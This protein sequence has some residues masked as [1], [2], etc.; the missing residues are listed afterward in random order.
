MDKIE[1]NIIPFKIRG[2]PQWSCDTFAISVKILSNKFNW[3]KDNESLT[4][5][6]IFTSMELLALAQ[7]WMAGPHPKLISA[8]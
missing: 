3:R 2:V 6:Y 7:C 4:D 8:Q 5:D 1:Q